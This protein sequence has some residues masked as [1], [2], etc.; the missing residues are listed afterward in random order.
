MSNLVEHVK[1]ITVGDGKV[2]YSTHIGTFNGIV[3]QKDGSTRKI[4]LQDTYLVPD[5]W[6]NLFSLT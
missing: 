2:I 3:A 5:L 4:Q 1:K 6:I